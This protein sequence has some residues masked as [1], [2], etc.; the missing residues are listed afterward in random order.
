MGVM[1]ATHIKHKEHRVQTWIAS[2]M[3]LRGGGEGSS[4]FERRVLGIGGAGLRVHQLVDLHKGS[5]L[6]A[7][8]IHEDQSLLRTVLMVKTCPKVARTSSESEPQSKTWQ[9]GHE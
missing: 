1:Y 8:P 7:T 4:S 3:Q 5:K 6:Q 9:S 2:N